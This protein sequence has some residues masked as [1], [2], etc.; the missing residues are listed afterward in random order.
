[1]PF[2]NIVSRTD[3]AALIPEDVASEIWSNVP[4]KSA[5]LSF[6]KTRNLSRAQQ[7]I[8]VKSV[9]PTAYFRNGDTGLMQTTEVN[10]EN[11][12]LNVE[13]IDCVVPVPKNVL[14][15]TDY[16]MWAE[17]RP[18]VEE[19]I[20]RTLDAAVFFE[21]GKPSSWPQGVV[22]AAIAAG[23][24]YTRGTNNAAAGGLA[25]DLNQVMGLVEDDGFDVGGFVSQRNYRAK[26]RSARDTTG[27]K[28]LDVSTNEIEG[29]PLAYSMNGLWPT[30]SGSAELV[31]GDFTQGIV[32]IRQDLEWEIWDQAVI[33]DSEGNIIYNLAQQKMVALAVTA[34]F[35]FA[36]PN[37]V[38]RQKSDKTQRYPFGVLVKP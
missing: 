6:F 4:A 7:R 9:L 22:P 19:A 2:D 32:G 28:L 30:A 3:A 23:N 25:E 38:S 20:G 13:E 26:L 11:V 31:A 8:P 18:D 35:A 34:R 21:V 24:T 1:V 17:V 27:Q 33:Q 12:Y 36:V 29:A 10:W 15:D 16:D 37:P 5:A 14:D